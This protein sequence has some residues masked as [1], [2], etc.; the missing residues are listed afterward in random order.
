MHDLALGAH[1]LLRACRQHALDVAR[2]SLMTTEIDGGREDR[3][4]HAAGGNIDEQR[5]DRKAGHALGGIHRKADRLLGLI[6]IDDHARLHAHRL[7][8]TDTDNL[9][10]VRASRKTLALLARPEPADDAANLCRAYIK[11]RHDAG[12]TRGS[13]LLSAKPTHM[14][15]S[16]G[17]YF[18]PRRSLSDASR[19]VAASGDSL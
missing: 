11:H 1:G 5:L 8:M 14:R 19:A 17:R 6:E 9:D 3:T 12:T 10:L 2:A 15:R 7:L 4:R 16:A 18:L 13:V